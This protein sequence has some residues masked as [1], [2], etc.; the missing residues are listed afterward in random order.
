MLGAIYISES[1]MS[2]FESGLTIISNNVANLNTAGYKGTEPIFADVEAQTESGALVGSEGEPTSGAGVTVQGD[3]ASFAQGQF[4]QTNNPLDAGIDGEGFFIVQQNGSDFYTRDGQF[5]IDSNGNLVDTANGAKVMVSTSSSAS[6]SFNVNSYLTYPPTAT[7]NVSLSGNLAQAGQTGPYTLPDITVYDSSGGTETLSAVFTQSTSNP[8]QWSVEVE[9]ASKNNIG[10]GTLIFGTDGTPAAGTTS[11]PVTV[12]PANLPAFKVNFSF[13][14]TGSF[15]GV[16][17]IS[18][19][20]GSQLQVENQDGVAVGVLTQTSFD[21]SGNVT[22][23]YSN[24]KTLTPAKLL[25]AQ[26]Q[27]PQQ[28]Q[29]LGAGMYAAVDGA[30]PLVGTP[31]TTSFGGLE[32]GEIEMSNVDLTQQLTNLITIQRGYQAASQVSQVADQ[33]LQQLLQMDSQG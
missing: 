4:Q 30:K 28:L 10:S 9:D 25:L 18:G 1:A 8:L 6:G 21:S 33:M 26:F 13:G 31:M 29:A 19:E 27:A 14:T 32:D 2:A 24:S 22:L 11:I 7:A 17:S 23:T 5:Q 3:D 16:T 20:S 12:T 15:S